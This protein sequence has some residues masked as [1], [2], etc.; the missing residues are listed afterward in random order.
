[1]LKNVFYKFALKEGLRN[2]IYWSTL[3][4]GEHVPQYNNIIQTG[5]RYHSKVNYLDWRILK[6]DKS[7]IVHFTFHGAVDYVWALCL[8]LKAG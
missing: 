8:F 2:H 4:N 6:V 7:G 5:Y 3:L 1:M